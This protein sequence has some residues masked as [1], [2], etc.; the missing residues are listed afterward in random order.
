MKDENTFPLP[1]PTHLVAVADP[2]TLRV[3]PAGQ[4]WLCECGGL[5]P[6]IDPVGVHPR[7]IMCLNPQCVNYEVELIAPNSEGVEARKV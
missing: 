4:E 7:R 5:L 6:S 2:A 1:I 3:Y